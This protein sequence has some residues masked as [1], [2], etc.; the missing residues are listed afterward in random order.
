MKYIKYALL[1]FIFICFIFNI[2]LITS[3]VLE[4]SSMFFNNVFISL[5]PF[6][7]LSNILIYFDYHIF[8]SD[9]FGNFI[10]KVFRVSKNASQIIILS[11]L[12]SCPSNAIFINNMYEK[13]LISKEECEKLIC[14]TCFPSLS[15]IIFVVGFTYFNSYKVGILL[16]FANFIY[17]LIIGLY[18]R[19][20]NT[21]TVNY[22]LIENKDNFFSLI[23]NTIINAFHTLFI[24]FSILAMFIILTNLI[25]EYLPINLVVLGIINGLLEFSSGI[26][27]I[28]NLPIPSNIKIS[29][30]SFILNFN[31]LSILFQI[32]S[33]INIKLNIKKILIIKLIF[34][35][36]ISIL[37]FF[38]ASC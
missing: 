26:S 1:S 7:I 6:I 21:F 27:F 20:D 28:A 34:S 18:L 30:I 19:K 8:L 35:F 2:K 10:S 5:F 9:I 32:S 23:K 33:I 24:I 38:I 37:V 11:I 4:A 31:S 36:L 14:F 22:N 16:L 29:I 3:S 15:Y 13:D 17:N 12:T 25:K